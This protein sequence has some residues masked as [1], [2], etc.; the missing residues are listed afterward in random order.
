M[1]AT[2]TRESAAVPDDRF[3]RRADAL[4]PLGREIDA[5]EFNNDGGLK[6]FLVG[7]DDTGSDEDD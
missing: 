3:A 5:P 6:C 4:D 7:F 1:T 2:V